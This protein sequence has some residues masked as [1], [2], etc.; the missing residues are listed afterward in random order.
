MKIAR[1]ISLQFHCWCSSAIWKRQQYRPMRRKKKP[2]WKNW[3]P[4][5]MLSLILSFCKIVWIQ[6][7]TDPWAN[8]VT[9][10]VPNT[11]SVPHLFRNIREFYLSYYISQ[12]LAP[13]CIGEAI[14]VS[15]ERRPWRATLYELDDLASIPAWQLYYITT[16]YDCSQAAVCCSLS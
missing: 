10:Q 6:M 15:Q 1:Y 13:S 2:G 5:Q 7:S 12:D 11:D 14:A 4:D 8:A 16:T 3:E 9:N